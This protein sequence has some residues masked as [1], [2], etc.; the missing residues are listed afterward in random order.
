MAWRSSGATNVDLVNNLRRHGVFSSERVK[1]AMVNVWKVPSGL[2]PLQTS[3]SVV[4][5]VMLTVDANQFAG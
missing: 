3:D 2:N 1:E 5:E 4:F